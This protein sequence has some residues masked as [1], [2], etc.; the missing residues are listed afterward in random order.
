MTWRRPKYLLIAMAL[1][2]LV[3]ALLL[4]VRAPAP[5]PPVES[6]RAVPTAIAG[7]REDGDVRREIAR[8][9]VARAAKAR[10]DPAAREALR[11]DIMRAL[12][13]RGVPLPEDGSPREDASS[14]ED[15]SPR[16]GAAPR[17]DA[18]T[19]SVG[20]ENRVGGHESLVKRLNEDFLPLADECMEAA[21]ERDPQLQGM[22]ALA[23]EVLAEK[24]LGAIVEHTEPSPENTVADPELLECLQQTLLSMA[25]PGDAVDGREGFMISLR[26]E[27]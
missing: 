16:E 19:P 14:R 18:P 22:V 20:L 8:P 5:E 27:P 7:G 17:D 26:T 21:R 2:I 24:D 4:G 23:V 9:T 3:S 10:R 25:L 13:R 12:E 15:G 6:R 11:R 1:L